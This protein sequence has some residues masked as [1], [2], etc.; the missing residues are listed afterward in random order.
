VNEYEAKVYLAGLAVI[1]GLTAAVVRVLRVHKKGLAPKAPQQWSKELADHIDARAAHK[2]NNAAAPLL[3]ELSN[4]RSDLAEWKEE[5]ADRFKTVEGKID[6]V[7]GLV[8]Q[9]R[10]DIAALRGELGF[11]RRNGTRK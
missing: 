8:T 5:A 7:Q 3:M 10:V 11:E 4:V 1:G 2:A 9:T 6:S